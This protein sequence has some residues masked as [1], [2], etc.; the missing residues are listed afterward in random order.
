MTRKAFWL[1][2]AVVPAEGKSCRRPHLTG[3]WL[4][5][6]GSMGHNSEQSTTASQLV[7]PR[8]LNLLKCRFA[9][10]ELQFGAF[11]VETAK[12]ASRPR[13]RLLLNFG[14]FPFLCCSNDPSKSFCL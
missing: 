5:N 10:T 8:A 9:C 11:A 1:I 4:P 13:F 6:V 14:S 12:S 3:S 7:G 2:L